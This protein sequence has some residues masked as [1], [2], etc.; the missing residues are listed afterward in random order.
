[1]QHSSH[2]K[3][4]ENHV[5][6]KQTSSNMSRNSRLT[7]FH[8]RRDTHKIALQVIKQF[9]QVVLV[10]RLHTKQATHTA[11]SATEHLQL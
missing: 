2:I 4:A 10:A 3:S 9:L 1:M 5:Y 8:I 7:N 6:N 11:P